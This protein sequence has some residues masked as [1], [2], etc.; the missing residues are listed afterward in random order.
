LI[1]L[2]KGEREYYKNLSCMLLNYMVAKKEKE[3][4]KS[5][6]GDI[7]GRKNSVTIVSENVVRALY[8][9]D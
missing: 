5:E 6:N 9:M 7:R 3:L 1:I 2:N 4:L 8:V